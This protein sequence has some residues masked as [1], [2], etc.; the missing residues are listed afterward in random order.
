VYKNKKPLMV[1]SGVIKK[2]IKKHKMNKKPLFVLSAPVET[3]SGYGGRSRDIAKAI[4]DSN[5]YEL[6]ILSQKWGNTPF[7]F[8]KEDNIEHMRIK[9]CILAGN[10]LPSK[11][12]VWAQCTVPN[13]F[14]CIGDYNIGITAGIETTIC[15]ASW[16]EG[17]NRMDL[18]FTSSTHS[19]DIFMN[20][21]FNKL[22]D[23][24]NIIGHI[25]VTK[26]IEVLF[27]GID[28]TIYNKN[29]QVTEVSNILDS[30]N[31]DFC[32]L[33]VGHWLQ[34]DIGQDRKDVGMLIKTFL[35]T[36]KGKPKKP[37]LILKT[38]GAT[39]S[40]LDKEEILEK[41]E[42]IKKLVGGDI[43]KIYL[44]HGEL[45]DE[46]INE[47]YNHSKVKAMISFT[48]GEGFGRP[49]LEFTVTGKPVIASNYS[50]HLDF[51]KYSALLGGSLKQIHPSAVVP[52]M[53]LA[54]SMWFEVDYKQ[55]SDVLENAYTNYKDFLGAAKKQTY[56][57]TKEFTLEKMRELFIGKLDE[58]IPQKVAFVLPKLIKI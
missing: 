18:T 43:P 9:R 45:A 57:S 3:Y 2:I 1:I 16:I 19:R 53:I 42:K 54:E 37:A 27:E 51:L 34:G 44:I 21:E 25:K 4:L 5:K 6:L 39:Y 32:F 38:N 14:T 12:R 52:N 22:D 50:G 40:T 20:T 15:D 58:I 10:Q 28:T 48:K 35:D 47:L 24:K 8:L 49:L 33:F 26:P 31:E 7:G 46:E 30:I 36:F 29:Y 11:P 17:I 13:E 55:A 41:I 23:K 56:L